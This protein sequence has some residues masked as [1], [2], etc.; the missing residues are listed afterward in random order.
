MNSLS[1]YLR[2]LELVR[3][4]SVDG[5]WFG[6][7]TSENA[8]PSP[9]KAHSFSIQAVTDNSNSSPRVVREAVAS[10]PGDDMVIEN[11]PVS[12]ARRCTAESNTPGTRIASNRHIKT[13]MMNASAAL[14]D[15]TSLVAASQY[16]RTVSSSLSCSQM[17]LTTCTKVSQGSTISSME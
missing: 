15:A 3:G 17:K 9:S 8:A 7:R 16:K 13:M 4:S 10:V 12:D 1:S 2:A 6:R 11:R 5:R 14:I